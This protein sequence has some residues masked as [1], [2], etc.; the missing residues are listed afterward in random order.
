MVLIVPRRPHFAL[1]HN[2]LEILRRS[3]FLQFD[4]A[5]WTGH[6][7][8]QVLDQCKVTARSGMELNSVEAII[9]TVRQ[10][11]GVSIVPKLANVDW[12][13]DRALKIVRLPG[14]EVQRRIGLLER[15]RHN[16]MRFTAALKEYFDVSIRKMR[17]GKGADR[18]ST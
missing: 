18:E 14:V 5:T 2:S 11:F 17:A 6:L 8:K 12:S 9:E 7:I 3:P 4:R 13:H 15:T 10:G 1:A 16:R